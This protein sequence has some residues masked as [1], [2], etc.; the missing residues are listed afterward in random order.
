MKNHSKILWYGN[1]KP[2][3]KKVRKVADKLLGGLFNWESTPQGDIYWDRVHSNLINIA[4]QLEKQ[5]K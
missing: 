2:S 3:A 4:A 1:N 5:E